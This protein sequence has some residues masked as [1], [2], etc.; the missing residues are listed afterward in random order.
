MEAMGTPEGAR[1]CPV[2]VDP[3][4]GHVFHA[5]GPDLGQAR[6][7]GTPCREAGC[8]PPSACRGRAPPRSSNS[9]SNPVALPSSTTAGGGKA[10]TRALRM[11]E[12]AFM[13]RSATAFA[14]RSEPVAELPV[15]ELDEYHAVVLRPFRKSRR[16]RSSCTIPPPLFRSPGNSAGSRPRLLRSAPGSTPV[17]S[18]TWASSM[19]W[20]SS[21]T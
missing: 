3:V 21:G 19:P 4:L 13:A 8:G 20:S 12:K 10:K 2:H 11:R 5:V 18:I 7:F 14:L 6:V 15:F 16:R 1:L 17:G 9:K